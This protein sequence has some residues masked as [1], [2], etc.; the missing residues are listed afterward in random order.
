MRANG[1]TIEIATIPRAAHLRPLV[2]ASS[3]SSAAVRMTTS[4]DEM[5]Q[6]N[7]AG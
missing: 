1:V 7:F 4:I 2:L 5:S 3:D 6:A